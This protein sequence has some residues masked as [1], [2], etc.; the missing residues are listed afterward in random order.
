MQI[1]FVNSFR[2]HC[3]GTG[4]TIPF[5]CYDEF[6]LLVSAQNQIPTNSS[7]VALGTVWAAAQ[8][9]SQ[10]CLERRESIGGLLGTAFVARD[11]IQVVDGL[12]EDGMLRYWGTYLIVG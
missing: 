12:E 6:S 8:L 1:L 5:Q 7:D 11:L 10:A 9:D 4:N 2:Y 3:S